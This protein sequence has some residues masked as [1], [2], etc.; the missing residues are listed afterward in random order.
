MPDNTRSSGLGSAGQAKAPASAPVP[1]KGIFHKEGEYWT[2]G[3]GAK[4]VRLKHSKGLVY[5]SYLLRHPAMEF[6]VLDLAG[7]IPA[8]AMEMKAILQQPSRCAVI[9]SSKNPEFISAD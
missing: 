1:Q 8:G 7:G 2:V 9:T 4:T 3:L 5:L 6:H